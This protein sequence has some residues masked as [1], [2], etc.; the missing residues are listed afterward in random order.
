MPEKK[1]LKFVE[2]KQVFEEASN[3]GRSFY[4]SALNRIQVA[5]RVHSSSE[6]D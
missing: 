3:W 5:L 1:Y 4:F 6:D 2:A